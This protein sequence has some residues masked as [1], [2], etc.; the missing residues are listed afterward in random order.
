MTAIAKPEPTMT[1]EQ[2]RIAVEGACQVLGLGRVGVIVLDAGLEEVV[3]NA[4]TLFAY[5][6]FDPKLLRSRWFE[7]AQKKG[8]DAHFDL[9]ITSLMVLVM[10]T[11]LSKQKTG[12]TPAAQAVASDLYR[13]Y[14]ISDMARSKLGENVRVTMTLN[15]FSHVFPD[16][17]AQTICCMPET[18]EPTGVVT[19]LP[20]CLCFPGAASLIPGETM[21]PD[22]VS[23]FQAFG[24]RFNAVI[25][26]VGRKAGTRQ[27]DATKTA[28]VD[29]LD[30]SFKSTL[31]EEDERQ[32]IIE[33]L[34]R[35][36]GRVLPRWLELRKILHG[37]HEQLL[38]SSVRQLSSEGVAAA[39]PSVS[40]TAE[41]VPPA[42]PPQTGGAAAESRPKS[43]Q[44][45]KRNK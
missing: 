45:G 16:V 37:G 17:V 20:R 18:F 11:N 36:D 15:R 13:V 3:E 40:A 39:S 8:R 25:N 42:T 19:Q 5:Q 43:Q 41:Q 14:S 31:F 1:A 9:V 2:F 23:D 4:S 35:L 32:E 33:R 7:T 29:W 26:K 30:L 6:G 10:G 21:S 38:A 28:D 34:T 24:A 12:L 27:E 44:A 22:V